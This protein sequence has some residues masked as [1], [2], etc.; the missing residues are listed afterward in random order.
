MI[1]CNNGSGALLSPNES[2][3]V[4]FLRSHKKLTSIVTFVLYEQTF[5]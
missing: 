2:I 5:G 4:C 3:N 1:P